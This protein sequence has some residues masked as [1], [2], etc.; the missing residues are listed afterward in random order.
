VPT[1][2]LSDRSEERAAPRRRR[3]WLLA[4][5][6]AAVLAVIA[7]ALALRGRRDAPPAA[8]SGPSAFAPVAG[9][10][11]LR[12]QWVLPTPEGFAVV[13]A[14]PAALV[15]FDE[16]GERIRD[17]RLPS[18]A[19]AAAASPSGGQLLIALRDSGVMV[20]DA[21][22]WTVVDR[23]PFS[24]AA[25]ERASG[26]RVSARIR[27]I[28]FAEGT[29]WA[30]VEGDDGE[31]ALLRLRR[32]EKKWVEASWGDMPAGYRLDARGARL[33]VVNDELWTVSAA[34]DS[35]ALH[36]VVGVTRV[37]AFPA[38]SV[39]AVRCAHD[40]A[41]SA[42]GNLLFVG[43]DGTLREM[44]RDGKKLVSDRPARE[45]SLPAAGMRGVR[46]DEI[47]ARADGDVFVA[48]SVYD[49][50]PA[51]LP[52][53]AVLYRVDDTGGRKLTQ[54]TET[55][56]TSLAVTPQ[57]ILAVVRRLDGSVDLL[58]MPR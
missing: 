9:V 36:R 13:T 2:S 57:S 22:K 28:A 54:L 55:V 1:S 10:A 17:V 39:D 18:E 31:A 5:L 44:R 16:G 53:A 14:N 40:V 56:I 42:A 49:D 26:G 25:V 30:A 37:D 51:D 23:V 4:G 58:S 34:S 41:Q 12:P 46:L 47:V 19:T 35:P 52:N 6:G 33:R 24:P 3:A 38:D 21:E 50:P 8:P 29:L 27:E 11:A 7:I 45:A 15:L 32:P 20:M 48:T 43:C